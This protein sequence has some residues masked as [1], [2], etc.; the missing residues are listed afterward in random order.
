MIVSDFSELF[1]ELKILKRLIRNLKNKI[2]S[3][4]SSEIEGVEN[5]FF[6][7]YKYTKNRI[8]KL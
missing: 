1:D 8:C 3:E 6:Y 5:E 2:L 4:L 7:F